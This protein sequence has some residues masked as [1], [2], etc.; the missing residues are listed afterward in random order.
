MIKILEIILLKINS[1]VLTKLTIF[2]IKIRY[3]K[4]FKFIHF[5]K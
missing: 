5:L 2:L 3:L 4:S 1:N